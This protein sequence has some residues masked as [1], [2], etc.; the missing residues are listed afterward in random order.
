MRRVF[1]K[2]AH[3]CVYVLNLTCFEQEKNPALFLGSLN[4]RKSERKKTSKNHLIKF[5]HLC[6][7]VLNLDTF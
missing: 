6:V 3:L 7:Y 2:G 5:A 1:E 4:Y